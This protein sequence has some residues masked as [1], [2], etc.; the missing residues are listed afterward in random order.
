MSSTLV[1]AR[2]TAVRKKVGPSAHKQGIGMK[3]VPSG[4]RFMWTTWHWGDGTVKRVS[5]GERRWE[6][7]G[8]VIGM[9]VSR[10]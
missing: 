3:T 4:C 6:T 5:L 7:K 8:R 10:S 9:C 2:D 1:R